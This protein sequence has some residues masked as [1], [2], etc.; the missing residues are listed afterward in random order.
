MKYQT[1]ALFKFYCR[2]CQ[3]AT[4]HVPEGKHIRCVLDSHLT[5]GY[6]VVVTYSTDEY[7]HPAILMPP[8]HAIPEYMKGEQPDP[9]EPEA[10]PSLRS[11]DRR[12]LETA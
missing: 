10:S 1:P 3:E 5:L 4:W 6:E 8:Q 12:L 7:E 11:A 2:G 9:E